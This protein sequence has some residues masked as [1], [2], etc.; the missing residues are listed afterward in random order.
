MRLC[1]FIIV[2]V[3]SVFLGFNEKGYCMTDTYKIVNCDEVNNVCIIRDKYLKYGLADKDLNIILPVEYSNISKN[4]DEYGNYRITAKNIQSGIAN[5]KGQIILEPIY[6]S[7]TSSRVNGKYQIQDS[8]FNIGLADAKTGNIDIKP[9]YDFIAA[10]DNGDYNVHK[11]SLNGVVSHN[12]LKL[13]VPVEYASIYLLN[14][15]K[16]YRL[17]KSIS[18]LNSEGLKEAKEVYGI[19]DTQGKVVVPL[20]CSWIEKGISSYK[21]PVLRNGKEFIFDAKTGKLSN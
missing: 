8:N 19:V 5:S 4:K 18:F 10:Y 16:Y 21:Y 2:S 7:I 3:F 20:D 15:G 17:E 14:G 9:A 1:L 6:R 13:I 12:T 11:D